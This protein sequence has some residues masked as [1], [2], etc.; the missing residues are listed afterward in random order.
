MVYGLPSTWDLAWSRQAEEERRV[1]PCWLLRAIASKV[2]RQGEGKACLRLGEEGQP[3]TCAAEP[4][5]C[6]GS[7]V[8]TQPAFPWKRKG[9]RPLGG[10]GSFYLHQSAWSLR[11]RRGV[12]ATPQ[13]LID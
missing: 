8:H 7:S 9:M 3:R 13:H 5:L 2:A 6:V 10:S 11:Q 12:E 4:P 1:S